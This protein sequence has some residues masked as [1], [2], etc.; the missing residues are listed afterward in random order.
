M[1]NDLNLEDGINVLSLFDGMS[2]GQIALQRLGIKVKNYFAAE[3]DKH[4]ITVTQKNYPKT[5]QLGDVT[6]VF[7]IDLPKI[8]LLI[9]GSPCQ[10]FSFAGKQLAFDDPRSML[11]FE[12][13]RLKEECNPTYFMLENVKMKKEF[14][15]IISKYLGIQP[16]EINSSLVSAQNRQR[17]YWTNI[18][19]HPSGF[20]GHLECMIPQP[21]DKGILLSHILEVNV[22]KKYQLSN[23]MMEYFNKR[24][25]NYNQGKINIRSE[26]GKSS[27][28][29]N[30]MFKNDISD[31]YVNVGVVN[32]EG[33]LREV[34]KSTCID[35]NYH[36]GMDNH[37]QRTMI[38][39][40]R[41]NNAFIVASRGRNPE[42]PK[43]REVG[44]KTEQ[45]IE[46]RH[47]GKTNCLTSVQ[48]DNLVCFNI[49]QH[50]KVRIHDVDVEGLKKLLK[51]HKK[52]T[53]KA[54]S[55]ALNVPLTKVA[56]WFRSDESFS[57]PDAEFWLQ[58][59]KL[60]N[61]GTDEFDKSIMEFDIKPNEYD[62]ANRAYGTNGKNPT[63]L[64]GKKDNLIVHNMMPR[65]STSGK[66]GSGHLTRTDGKTYCLDT[67]Q[68]NAIEI[69]GFDF[70]F[71]GNPRFRENGKAGTL[72]ARARNDESCGQ[73]VFVN[74]TIIRRLTPVECERLQTVPDNYTKWVSD[75]QR[76]R[77]L[78]NGWTVDVIAHIFS[79][80]KNI[81][82]KNK[83]SN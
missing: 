18:N 29:T 35:S 69:K 52:I 48:K 16:I 47:D 51:S 31:N 61:I 28:L 67:G 19:A 34:N 36:K 21:K 7:G 39:D 63:L 37:S 59:K 73:S 62:Q 41:N 54:I 24:S 14:E 33:N 64:A 76:Y 43:S 81:P 82:M 70:D 49:Q 71:D 2:C 57:I 79:F 66:G 10:G 17:L 30:S 68:T 12:Y 8:H 38:L 60:L 26:K 22:D 80:M 25:K 3:I 6:K 53:T 40:S 9:G 20:F 1:M 78:G 27:C 58:L 74:N 4:A 45:M 44:L 83:Q 11:F 23:K 56:H 55:K 72:K 32:Q 15:V 65:S 13:V 75:T 42:N 50:V 5:I 77:M 46:P